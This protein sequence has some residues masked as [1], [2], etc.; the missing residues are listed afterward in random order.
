[1]NKVLTKHSEEGLTHRKCFCSLQFVREMARARIHSIQNLFWFHLFVSLSGW[2][3]T[4]LWQYKTLEPLSLCHWGWR[5]LTWMQGEVARET[6]VEGS[7]L[8]IQPIFTKY[9]LWAWH[10][11]NAWDAFVS[12][13]ERDRVFSAFGLDLEEF[14]RMR[15]RGWW[16]T[17]LAKI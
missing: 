5:T 12:G 14:Q 1:M 9:S 10:P 16:K 13:N 8:L 4:T 11:A 2:N 17:A 3:K 6:F 15:W 7:Y